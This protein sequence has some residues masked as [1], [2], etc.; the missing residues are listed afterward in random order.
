MWVMNKKMNTM[1]GCFLCES[2]VNE[3][4]WLARA[5]ESGVHEGAALTSYRRVE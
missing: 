1:E 4:E 3:T 2:R 5:V